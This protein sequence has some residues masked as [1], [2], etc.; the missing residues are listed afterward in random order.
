VSPYASDLVYKWILK[1][2]RACFASIFELQHFD[3][4]NIIVITMFGL[5]PFV[6]APFYL[7]FNIGTFAM[8]TQRP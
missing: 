1:R 6:T 2:A 4:G 7:P 5:L 3:L 8:T